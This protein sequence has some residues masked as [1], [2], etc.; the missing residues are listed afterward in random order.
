MNTCKY[1]GEVLTRLEQHGMV[2]KWSKCEFMV[3]SV[4]FLGYRADAEGR[5]PT[6]E[7]IAAKNCSQKI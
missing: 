4:Q 3:P 6:D 5:H 1:R 7:K 2:A